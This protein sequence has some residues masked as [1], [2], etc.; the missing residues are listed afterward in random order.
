MF[1]SVANLI[2]GK[3]AALYWEKGISICRI[4]CGRIKWNKFK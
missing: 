4:F 1:L 2:W 3:L